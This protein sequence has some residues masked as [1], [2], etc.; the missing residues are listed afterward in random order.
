MSLKCDVTFMHAIVIPTVFVMLAA[1][2]VDTVKHQSG[3]CVSVPLGIL[4][5]PLMWIALGPYHDHPLRWTKHLSMF[6]ILHFVQMGP[7]K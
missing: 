2:I 5:N 6:H 3:V 1:S 7:D 4:S